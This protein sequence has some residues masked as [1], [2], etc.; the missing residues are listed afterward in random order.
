V[1]LGDAKTGETFTVGPR[2]TYTYE[3]HQTAN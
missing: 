2:E 1:R 3:V